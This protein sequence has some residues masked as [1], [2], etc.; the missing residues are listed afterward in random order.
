M[1]PATPV[2]KT[3]LFCDDTVSSMVVMS[4]F[5]RNVVNSMDSKKQILIFN[6]AMDDNHP[7]FAHQSDIVRMLSRHFSRVVVVTARIGNVELPGN[8]SVYGT[9]WQNGKFFTNVWNYYRVLIRLKGWRRFEVIFFHM[10]VYQVILAIP[11][12]LLSKSKKFLWYA[13]RQNSLALSIACSQMDVVL[14]STR[15]SFP[16]ETSK[17]KLVGQMVDCEKFKVHFPPNLSNLRRFVHI[18]RLDASKQIDKI[19]EALVSIKSEYPAIEFTSYGDSVFS[20]FFKRVHL[21]TD[22]VL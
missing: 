12:L 14:S 22:L 10:V 6:F 2:I 7:I 20:K 16:F 8:V 13:H 11:L 15:G 1:K 5:Y 3:F 18:G 21:L 4:Q 17:I 9:S 19:I